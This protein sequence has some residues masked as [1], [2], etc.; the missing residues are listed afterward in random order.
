M[1]VELRKRQAVSDRSVKEFVAEL[2]TI[3]VKLILVT[4]ERL[5]LSTKLDAV[6]AE[7]HTSLEELF[8]ERDDR[9]H[10]E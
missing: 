1:V 10:A 2:E 8:G 7:S 4:A 9:D 3:K 5:E 6:A